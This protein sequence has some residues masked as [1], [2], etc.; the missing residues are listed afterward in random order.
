MRTIS[1]W[2]L[3]LLLLTGSVVMLDAS[4]YRS[5]ENVTIEEPTKGNLYTAGGELRILAP[6]NGD[7]V[8]AG[9]KIWINDTILNDGLI[10]GG[11]ISVEA[12][13]KG[14]LRVAGGQ[15]RIRDQVMGDLILMGGEV[16]VM[17]D[18]H[19]GGDLIIMSGQAK[20]Y[21][22]VAGKM[23]SYSG[24]L[25][26]SG[27]AAG[28]LIA[29]GG[30][31]TVNGEVRGPSRLSAQELSVGPEARF[32][33]DVRYWQEEGEIDFGDRLK[34]GATATF[35]PTL[36]SDLATFDFKKLRRGLFWFSVYRFMAGIVLIVLLI[37]MFHRFFSNH[38]GRLTEQL[39]SSLGYGALYLIGIPVLAILAF[40]TVI[41]IPVGFILT[42]GYSI[43][44]ALAGALV[45]TVLA[46]E[47]EKYLGKKWNKGM[48]MLIA[49]AISLLLRLVGYIPLV[50]SI[51]LVLLVAVAFGYLYQNIQRERR[52]RRKLSEA[53]IV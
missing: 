34:D 14:D 29:R 15:V 41:G 6:V 7:L 33:A 31:V 32:F 1:T 28:E 9:G 19:I 43:T 12:A 21:G 37:T 16:E 24:Q 5:G 38:A 44:L 35:D 23:H 13:I 52:M 11:E 18:A 30:Q 27:V 2:L 48:M 22:T 51:I 3:T 17:P 4:D 10:G 47:F 25:Q 20:V 45:A 49:I 39:A 42:A 36:K 26:F 53:D 8:A 40:I 50:G 46:Y